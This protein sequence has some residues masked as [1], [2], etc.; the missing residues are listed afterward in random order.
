MEQQEA[1]PS[2][3]TVAS[4]QTVWKTLTVTQQEMVLRTMVWICRQIA[5]QWGREV[6]REP[7]DE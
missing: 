5:E 1:I 6:D 3:E 7:R 2:M 4:P